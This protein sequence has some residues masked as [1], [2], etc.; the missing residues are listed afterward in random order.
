VEVVRELLKHVAKL[1]SVVIDDW[2]PLNAAALSQL[3]FVILPYV[4]CYS[5]CSKP[6]KHQ[7]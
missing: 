7:Y 2:S 4:Y 5:S 6:H 3:M 1:E